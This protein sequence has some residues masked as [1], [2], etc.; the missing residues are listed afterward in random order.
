M[1]CIRNVASKFDFHRSRESSLRSFPR[2]GIQGK[3]VY[4]AWRFKQ[5]ATPL[6]GGLAVV[7]NVA[8]TSFPWKNLETRS[9]RSVLL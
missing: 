4:L 3:V 8:S 9:C 7:N 6:A 1:A 5:P 2:E